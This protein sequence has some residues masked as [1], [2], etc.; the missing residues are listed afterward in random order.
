L[1]FEFFLSL[2]IQSIYKKMILGKK[3]NWV[4]ISHFVPMV[5][6]TLD[7]NNIHW[8]MKIT[9]QLIYYIRGCIVINI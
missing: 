7:V 6:V 5:Q 1:N 9:I 3:F 4:I 8:D 2:E